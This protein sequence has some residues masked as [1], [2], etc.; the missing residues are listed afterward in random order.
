MLVDHLASNNDNECIEGTVAKK[1]VTPALP[2]T[3][4][5][6]DIVREYQVRDERFITYISILPV[7]GV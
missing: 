4:V 1:S 3:T 6:V 5:N 2:L 7:Q